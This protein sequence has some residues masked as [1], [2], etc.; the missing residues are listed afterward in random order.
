M[1]GTCEGLAYYALTTTSWGVVGRATSRET[2]G[3][4]YVNTPPAPEGPE[5][6]P[7]LAS[8]GSPGR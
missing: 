6:Y 7:R 3:E 5:T 8:R 2:R 4:V 1:P